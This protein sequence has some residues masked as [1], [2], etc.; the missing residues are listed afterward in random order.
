MPLVT[1]NGIKIW[2]CISGAGTYH[3][4]TNARATA[5]SFVPRVTWVED[6]DIAKAIEKRWPNSNIEKPHHD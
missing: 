1:D 4:F 5:E 6:E 2:V 3:V